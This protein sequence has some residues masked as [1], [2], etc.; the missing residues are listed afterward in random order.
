M[1]KSYRRSGFTLTELLVVISIIGTLATLTLFTIAGVQEDAEET[2]AEAQIDRITKYLEDRW[3]EYYVRKLPF[4]YEDF[5]NTD[6]R[7][8]ISQLHNQALVEMIRCEF[9]YQLEQL[10]QFPSANFDSTY[11]NGDQYFR[12]LSKRNRIARLA[13]MIE[14]PQ[15][16]MNQ[17]YL[18]NPGWMDDPRAEQAECLYLILAT[19]S[20]Y[21]E[22]GTRILRTDEIGDSDGD[23]LLEVLDPWGEPLAFHTTIN[24]ANG[25]DLTNDN[26]FPRQFETIGFV[27]RSRTLEVS[28]G[29]LSKQASFPF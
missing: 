11:A 19:T 9:P 3:E 13:G 17:T 14:D 15:F 16:A 7:S 6:E 28:K 23:G 2:R 26:P 1:T 10:G 12:S 25:L 4:K 5:I 22:P 27:I 8:L 18:P 21:G 29:N 24:G 20:D